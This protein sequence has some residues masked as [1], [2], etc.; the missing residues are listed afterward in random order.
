M[1]FQAIGAPF[2]TFHSSCGTRTPSNFSWASTPQDIVVYMDNHFGLG[3]KTPFNRSKFGWLCESRAI[4]SELIEHVKSY[5]L[6]YKSRYH[7][8]FTCDRDLIQL[9]EDFFVFNLAA[10]NLPW[11][12]ISEYGIHPKTKL[13]SFICSNRCAVPGHRFRISCAHKY[14][15]FVDMYGNFDGGPTIGAKDQSC[16]YGYYHQPKTEALKEY[17]FSIVIEN[18]KYDSYFTEKITDCFANGVIPVYYG[19][20]SIK[21]HFNQN[22]IIE[23][24]DSFDPSRLNFDLYYS[25]FEAVYDNYLRVSNML[26]ADDMLYNNILSFL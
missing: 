14:K 12:P 11:T 26:S 2:N 7:K 17:C 10:S 19:T 16:P 3:L 25:K 4:K 20:D 15:N 22:G 1:I 9:D 18:D 23:L 5:Y 6:L 8:V 24:Q 21:D 13:V